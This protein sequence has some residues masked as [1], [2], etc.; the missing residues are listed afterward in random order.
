[1][2]AA[3]SVALHK[4]A[5]D[6][7]NWRN[8]NYPVA[9]SD[10]GLHTW[11]NRLADYSA[12]KIAERAQHVRKLL[13]QVRAMKTEKWAKDDRI[14]WLLFRAQLAIQSARNIDPLFKESTA[15]L[16]KDLSEAERVDFEKSRDSALTAIHAFA[17]RLEKKLPQMVDFAPMGEANY[18]YYLK[19]VLLLPLN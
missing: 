11:D 10:A 4:L 15:P 3:D 9:S 12:G 1:T 18:N 14:D 7:Y 16:T 6:Y 13:D 17:D 5:D 8:E 19:H 2:S